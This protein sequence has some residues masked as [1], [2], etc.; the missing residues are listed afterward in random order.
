MRHS[1]ATGNALRRHPWRRWFSAGFFS[2]SYLSFHALAPMTTSTLTLLAC[3]AISQTAAPR[4]A[5]TFETELD[6]QKQTFK[7]WW[8]NDLVT[9]LDDLPVEGAVPG[10]RTPYSGHDY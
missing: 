5:P 8:G 2:P 7:Q 6:Y 10:F 9:K 4:R 3:L 1:M